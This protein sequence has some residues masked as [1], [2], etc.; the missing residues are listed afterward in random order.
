MAFHSGERRV[1]LN[2]GV[3]VSSQNLLNRSR[4]YNVFRFHIGKL[5]P[6]VEEVIG[7]PED[8]GI[9]ARATGFA[10]SFKIS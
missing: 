7:N 3:K 6:V 4:S 8:S 10:T 5:D 2:A 1:S 9:A